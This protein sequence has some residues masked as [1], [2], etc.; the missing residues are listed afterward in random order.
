MY[1]L[2][3]STSVVFSIHSTWSSDF[4]RKIRFLYIAIKQQTNLFRSNESCLLP[5]I[6][7]ERILQ[8]SANS[9]LDVYDAILWIMTI[10]F[11]LKA[12]WWSRQPSNFL[13]C[14]NHYKDKVCFLST[15]HSSH[16]I[17]FSIVKNVRNTFHLQYSINFQCWISIF[18]SDPF[19]QGTAWAIFLILAMLNKLRCHAHF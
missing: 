3:R 15:H 7:F 17:H 12:S 10:T 18:I 2:N 5:Q 1:V 19:V 8:W 4:T 14:E 16:F 9:E 11:W 13:F 6:L